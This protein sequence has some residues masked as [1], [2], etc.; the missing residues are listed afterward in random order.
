MKP[1]YLRIIMRSAEETEWELLGAIP[2][3]IEQRD[4]FFYIYPAIDRD[5]FRVFPCDEIIAIEFYPVV[6]SVI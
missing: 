5:G 3:K 6:E 1:M 2:P 4:G